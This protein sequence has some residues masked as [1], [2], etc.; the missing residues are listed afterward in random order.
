MHDKTKKNLVLAVASVLM[1]CSLGAAEPAGGCGG[2][3]I[4]VVSEPLVEVPIE[5]VAP[6]VYEVEGD[7][8]P[9]VGGGVGTLGAV[10]HEWNVWAMDVQA[11]GAIVSGDAMYPLLDTEWPGDAHELSA[12]NV[13]V[14]WGSI[15]ASALPPTPH[16]NVLSVTHTGLGRYRVVLDEGVATVLVPMV[17]VMGTGQRRDANVMP[18]DGRTFDIYVVNDRGA[19][20]DCDVVFIVFGF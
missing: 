17:T 13:P 5:E 10:G 8:Q 3:D 7:F 20:T 16:Y 15:R 1:V 14:A 18:V 6:G 2:P 11:T 19:F 4:A 12:R 9:K